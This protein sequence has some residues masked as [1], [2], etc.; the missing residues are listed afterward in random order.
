MTK[1]LQPTFHTLKLVLRAL[2]NTMIDK[3][4]N[5]YN[6]VYELIEN[7]EHRDKI[8]ITSTI[9]DDNGADLLSMLLA[10][11]KLGVDKFNFCS[12]HVLFTI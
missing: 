9:F 11:W 2:E 4:E 5:G 12:Y 8:N 7:V 6:T 1:F 3:G 10:Y